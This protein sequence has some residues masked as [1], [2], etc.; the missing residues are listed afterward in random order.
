M[1]CPSGNQE[2]DLLVIQKYR[3]LVLELAWRYWRTLPAHTKI[4]VDPDD[5][6]EDA[7]IYVLTRVGKRAW[8]PRRGAQSTYLWCGISS[9]LLNF[10]L[11]QQTKK[12]FGY[13]LPL[14]DIKAIALPD[15]RLATLEAEEALNKTYQEASRELKWQMKRWFGPSKPRFGH[16][17]KSFFLYSE[18]RNLAARHR[19]TS[20][21]CRRLM[22]SGVWID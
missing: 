15:R 14:E 17:D 4:W 22:G 10:A 2:R 7:Y 21:D 20:E 8:N 11:S 9:I 5:L 16:S 3:G 12:R 18:F 1:L 6:I 19:L 13:R